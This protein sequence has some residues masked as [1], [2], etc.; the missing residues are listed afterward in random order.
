[1]TE[2]TL[3][4]GST[5][6]QELELERPSDSDELIFSVTGHVV[7]VENE[8]IESIMQ[9]QATSPVSLTVETE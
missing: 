2:I 9:A 7:G 6:I 5:Q 4:I 8:K 1:M 3:D